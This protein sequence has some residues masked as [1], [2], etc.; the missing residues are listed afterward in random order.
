MF[1]KKRITSMEDQKLNAAAELISS[2]ERVFEGVDIPN[3]KDQADQVFKILKN[4]VGKSYKLNS[5][6]EL[7]TP[8]RVE[9]S[10]ESKGGKILVR[11]HGEKPVV[12]GLGGWVSPEVAGLDIMGRTMRVG[13]NG[14][15]PDLTVEFK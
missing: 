7:K 12:S 4:M 14:I 8:E 15:L 13:L 6:L 3:S 11:F 2:V 5:Y 1:N 9:M 10:V